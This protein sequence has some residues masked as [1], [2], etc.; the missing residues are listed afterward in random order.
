MN[1]LKKVKSS[2]YDPLYYSEILNMNF[3]GSLKYF[4]KLSLLL[5]LVG[6]IYLSFVSI[7]KVNSFIS[8][9]GDRVV[10]AYP[11]ELEVRLKDGLVST[12]VVEP[13]IIPLPKDEF[14][15]DY[16]KSNYEN[17]I[18]IDTKSDLSLDKFNAYNTVVL[19]TKNAVLTR[20]KG[21]ITIT[22][23]KG[24]SDLTI[25]RDKLVYW[26]GKVTPFVKKL[27]YI[28]PV[29]VFTG[30]F[31]YFAFSLFYLLFVALLVFI[32]G[33]IRK[34]GLSYKKS[35]QISLHAITLPLILSMVSWF[36]NIKMFLFV[37]TIILLVVVWVNL[38]AKNPVL[39]LA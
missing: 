10:E 34:L 12:N 4:F 33:K 17:L 21:K 30:L 23:L 27:P 2:V 1:F 25:N 38:K 16:N 5:A 13:Y 36:I 20:D 22:E 7:P 9:F 15:A 31:L 8:T 29:I 11:A 28:I 6:A 26:V 24:T 32:I 19:L 14:N 39:P 3:G 18:V 37:P 35:Y